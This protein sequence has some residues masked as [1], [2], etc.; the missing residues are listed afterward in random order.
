M[1]RVRYWMSGTDPGQYCSQAAGDLASLAV[2][3]H[4]VTNLD[5]NFTTVDT[6]GVFR[7]PFMSREQL[8]LRLVRC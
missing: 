8:L 2:T 7:C 6:N 5:L 4:N 1:R 3:D